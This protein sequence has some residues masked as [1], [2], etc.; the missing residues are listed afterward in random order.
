MID[1]FFGGISGNA[2]DRIINGYVVD[3][4]YFKFAKY[5]SPIFNIADIFQWIGLIILIYGLFKEE[6]S[7]W[8]ENNLRNQYI[9]DKNFQLKSSIQYCTIYIFSSII[10]GIFCFTFIKVTIEKYAPHLWSNFI[11]S[12]LMG[13][14]S[15]S[16]FMSIIFFV[17]GIV[18]SHRTSGPIYAFKRF[19]KQVNEGQYGKLKLRDKDNHK[20][21]EHIAQKIQQ[22]YIMNKDLLDKLKDQK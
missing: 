15:L 9:I 2:I 17:I 19:L 8:Y 1:I 16:A 12:F 11:K 6:K 20:E 13:Y 22:E 21:L 5:Y 4:I 18:L 10:I 3:F 14:I 7:I